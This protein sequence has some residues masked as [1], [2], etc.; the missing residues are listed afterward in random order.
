MVSHQ[1]W[2]KFIWV[3]LAV[4]NKNTQLAGF[5]IYSGDD[6]LMQFDEL[7]SMVSFYCGPVTGGCPDS[8]Q[9][10]QDQFNAFDGDSSTDLD[11]DE[12]GLLVDE[13]NSPHEY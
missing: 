7:W 2:Q 3:A 5:D 10:M 11:R 13:W 6:E 12:Y 8:P 4:D 9:D 1:V